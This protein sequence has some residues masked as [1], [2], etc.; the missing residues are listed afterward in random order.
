M[1]SGQVSKTESA[2]HRYSLD[3]TQRLATSLEL[4]TGTEVGVR[5]W[6]D[7]F[8]FDVH[9]VVYRL[10][11]TDGESDYAGPFMIDADG[12]VRVAGSL[13][14]NRKYAFIIEALSSEGENVQSEVQTLSVSEILDACH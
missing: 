3:V 5:A 14:E 4:R 13:D 1:V 2:K 6:P 7:E 8:D 12:V 10:L 9:T 11:E